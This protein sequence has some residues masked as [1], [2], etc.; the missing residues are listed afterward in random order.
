MKV[1]KE[2]IEKSKEATED[3]YDKKFDTD[4]DTE[5]REKIVCPY[6]GYVDNY[7]YEYAEEEGYSICDNCDEEFEYKVDIT[8]KYS[9]YKKEK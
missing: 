8:V 5:Y 4:K 2:M 3:I 6:C 9:T 1:P 7:P